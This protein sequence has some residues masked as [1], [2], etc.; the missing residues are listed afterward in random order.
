MSERFNSKLGGI[1][2]DFRGDS[3]GS[4]TAIASGGRNSS[5]SIISVVT[6]FNE[7]LWRTT[8]AKNQ[9]NQGRYQKTC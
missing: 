7:G 4:A 6:D 1:Y 8:C 9:A 2:H 3:N 5:F